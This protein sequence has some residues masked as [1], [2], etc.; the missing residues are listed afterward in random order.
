MH[1][2][3]A[4]TVYLT[5]SWSVENAVLLGCYGVADQSTVPRDCGIVQLLWLW[6]ADLSENVKEKG[7]VEIVAFIRMLLRIHITSTQSEG[8]GRVKAVGIGIRMTYRV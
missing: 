6:C 2:C 5:S 8:K 1:Y 3:S 4:F 7:R